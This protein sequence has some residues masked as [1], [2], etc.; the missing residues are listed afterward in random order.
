MNY[1]IYSPKHKR[2]NTKKPNGKR[3][4]HSSNTDVKMWLTQEQLL[5]C[6]R[7]PT[8]RSTLYKYYTK[9]MALN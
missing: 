2:E 5:S 1:L 4:L 8:T 3:L 7:G 6:T 9:N